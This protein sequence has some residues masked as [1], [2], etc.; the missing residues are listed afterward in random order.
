MIKEEIVALLKIKDKKEFRKFSLTM[1]IFFMLV[2]GVL[3]W[4]N[5]VFFM[6]FF[7]LGLSFLIFGLLFPIIL[8]P[9][10]I[11]WMSFA[12]I[13][14]FVMTRIILG[15]IFYGIFTPVSI[16]LKLLGKDF[17]EQKIDLNVSS[18]WKIRETKLY[19]PKNSEN[20]F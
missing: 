12:I 11:I 20:Q 2:G 19:D 18:Y 6:F 7:Y 9:V 17:L 15:I 5:S 3:F 1:G 16:F 8:K 13:V 4:I 10:F 14:G